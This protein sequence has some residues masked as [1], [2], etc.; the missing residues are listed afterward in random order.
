MT[1]GDLLPL[2]S[3]AGVFGMLA[4]VGY[5]LHLDAVAAH[6][7]RANDW[8]QVAKLA[9]ERAD[10]ADTRA[11]LRDEQVRLILDAIKAVAAR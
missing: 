7:E 2:L 9:D 4:W 3:Q 10:R 1:L 5:R 11:D 6:R 8:R